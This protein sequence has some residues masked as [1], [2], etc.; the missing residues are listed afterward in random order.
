MGIIP[1]N[2]HDPEPKEIQLL[3]FAFDTIRRAHPMTTV[4]DLNEELGMWFEHTAETLRNT[5]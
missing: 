5:E 4:E 3:R 2:K 1:Y